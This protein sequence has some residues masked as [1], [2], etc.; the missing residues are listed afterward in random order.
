ML[1][2][3][4]FLGRWGNWV[5]KIFV[6]EP[7]YFSWI[8]KLL[9]TLYIL[10]QKIYFL[11]HVCTEYFPHR[12]CYK[13]HETHVLLRL[14]AWHIGPYSHQLEVATLGNFNRACFA[15]LYC[16]GTCSCQRSKIT[17]ELFW[18]SIKLPLNWRN[19]INDASQ[20]WKNTKV[21]VFNHKGTRMVKDGEDWHG[22]QTAKLIEKFR[23]NFSNR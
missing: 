4:W 6:Q 23:L 18:A 14:F 21:M 2:K 12:I 17:P 7:L 20:R 15:C 16:T 22:S 13:S 8:L 5:P 11:I 3:S 19:P 9:E 1:K 10:S